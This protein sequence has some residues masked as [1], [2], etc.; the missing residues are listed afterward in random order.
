MVLVAPT[1]SIKPVPVIVKSPELVN[2]RTVPPETRCTVPE[3]VPEPVEEIVKLK[4][5]DVPNV[6]VFPDATLN[7]APVIVIVLPA[8]A[9]LKE[10][11]PL[12]V[13]LFKLIDGTE[14]MAVRDLLKELHGGNDLPQRCLGMDHGRHADGAD[15]PFAAVRPSRGGVGEK[16]RCPAAG[17]GGGLPQ[18]AAVAVHVAPRC[19]HGSIVVR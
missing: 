1:S 16:R 19:E 12:I 2:V 15:D 18:P 7:D 8:V 13:R 6:K 3:I 11:V 5:L 17:H 4:V 10:H 14:V 9:A